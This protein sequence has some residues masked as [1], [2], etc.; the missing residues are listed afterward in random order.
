MV[1][2]VAVG[3]VWRI[4]SKWATRVQVKNHYGLPGL[5]ACPGTSGWTEAFLFEPEGQELIYLSE[6]DSMRPGKQQVLKDH[7]VEKKM[8]R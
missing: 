3:Y 4:S 6:E 2:G 1:G 5:C 7:L 8:S